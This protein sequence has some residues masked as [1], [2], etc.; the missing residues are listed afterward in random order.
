MEEPPRGFP[1]TEHAARLARAQRAMDDAGLDALLL[2]TEADL[3][4]FS[5][6]LTAFWQSPTRP[7]FLVVP[8]AGRPVAVIPSIG[9]PCMRRTWLDDVR[10]WCAP[11]PRD[12]GVSLLAATLLELAGPAPRIGVPMGQGTHLRMPLADHAALRSR[13]ANA[14]WRDA[15]PLLAS[16][17]MIKSPAEVA[18]IRHACRLASAAFARLPERLPAG[19]SD[20]D[21]F[22]AFRL[23]ALEAGADD[24]PYLVGAAGDGGYADIISPP[25]GRALRAG[26]VLIL[27]AGCTHD[28]HF[29][30]FD[31]NW[32]V[33][34]ATPAVDE[35]YRVAW[36]ATEAGIAA[37]RPGARVGDLFEAMRSAM[38]P[39][40]RDAPGGVGRLGH[41]LGTELT[42]PPSIVADEPTELVPGMVLAL[43]PGY[44]F[45]PGR[46]MVHEENVMITESGCELLSVRAPESLPR[47][48]WS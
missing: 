20:R 43:E 27:D 35:A 41:G 34:H 7:W 32:A 24:V 11:D 48:P 37:A 46:W 8:A 38:T 14:R 17:R 2:T 45:A 18:K 15:G 9:E 30:D 1:A 12:D 6:F 40:A 44:A 22:R 31:R 4:W 25:S 36:R 29:S 33:G 19:A 13:L 42:E 5:G 16:L 47:I 10:T 39:R 21:A 23:A 3:R 28:G 26:D